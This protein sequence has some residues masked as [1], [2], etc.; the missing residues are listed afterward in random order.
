MKNM[1][2]KALSFV[3]ALVM[4]LSLVPAGVFAAEEAAVLPT[5]TVTE[6][7][8]EEL[9]LTFALNFLADDATQEQLDQ[10]GDWP[11]DFV[12]TTNKTITFNANGGADGYL[13]GQYDAW[14]ENWVNVPFED[15]T[16]EANTSLK[17]M[18]YAMEMMG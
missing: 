10:Y 18:A 3:V 9:G 15:A 2:K 13:S 14:S 1:F 7:N 6:L 17:I 8:A 16:L 4:V 5:A 11:A 12:L